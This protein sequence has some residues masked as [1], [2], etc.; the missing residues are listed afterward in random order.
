MEKPTENFV[1]P[2][3]VCIVG[4]TSS[5]KTTFTEKLKSEISENV[6]H[7]GL[8]NF[9]VGIPKGIDPMDYDFDHPSSLDFDYVVKCVKELVQTGQTKVPMYDFKTHSRVKDQFI[10]L[11]ADKVIIFEGR[12]LMQGKTN[13]RDPVS[14]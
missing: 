10:T 9:Y 5:G 3:M 12:F 6:T 14:A 2:L 13:G 11:K 4:G 7:F 8:D 1:K